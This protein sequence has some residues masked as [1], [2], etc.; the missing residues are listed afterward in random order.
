[1]SWT[2]LASPWPLPWPYSPG[3]PPVAPQGCIDTVRF[4][5]GDTD[6]TDQQLSDSE[7]VG[8]L[9]QNQGDPYQS[10]IEGCRYLA[11]AY[12]RQVDK[13]TGDF[14][15]AASQRHKAYLD[16]I[17]S[18]SAQSIRF[19]TPRPFAGGISESDK[20]ANVENDDLVQPA[21]T[22]GMHDDPG[23]SPDFTDMALQGGGW[24]GA[25]T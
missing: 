12:A 22:R 8:V 11:A 10:A 16:L 4:L 3:P 17:K 14:H 13:T 19:G 1:M 5:I 2:Y 23:T 7:I 25:D 6:T 24:F 20:E 21:F 15:I 18:L 9:N